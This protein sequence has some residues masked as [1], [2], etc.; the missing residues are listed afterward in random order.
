MTPR[1]MVMVP[2][3]T[4][5]VMVPTVSAS[6]VMP[7]VRVLQAMLRLTVPLVMLR[8]MQVL[9]LGVGTCVGGRWPVVG[10][11]PRHPWRG[12]V[13]ALLAGLPAGPGGVCRLRCGVAPRR[14]WRRAPPV[15]SMV[16]Q[17]MVRLMLLLLREGAAG[18]ATGGGAAGDVDGE[19][20]G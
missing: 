20:A 8:V 19:G 4:P 12:T 3:V 1:V 14:S 18:A 13:A 6:P 16:L 11:G 7:I 10:V 9:V 17:V 2:L 15:I 5:M